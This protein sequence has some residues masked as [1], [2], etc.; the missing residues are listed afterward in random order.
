ML[1][2][3]E[4]S[5][6]IDGPMKHAYVLATVAWET[7]YTYQPITEYGGEV[8]LKSKRYF[9]FYGRGYVQL[10]WESNYR[11]FGIALNLDLLKNPTLAKVPENAWAILEMGM[12]DTIYGLQDPDF[13]KWTLEDF[14]NNDKVDFLN[15]RKIINP[16]DYGSYLPIKEMADKLLSCL[17]ASIIIPNIPV[18]F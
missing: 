14:I 9:P 5:K 2:K 8:Y 7:A 18:R 1:D 17:Q 12:T 16:K 3:L 4:G 10:T 15:A 13:T 11:K 6:R